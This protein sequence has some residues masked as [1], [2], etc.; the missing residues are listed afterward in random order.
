MDLGRLRTMEDECIAMKAV[1]MA[2]VSSYD[3]LGYKSRWL[4]NSTRA[5]RHTAALW[6]IVVY[7]YNG[8]SV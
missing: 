2:I 7:M 8:G 5:W 6:S 3:G 4:G 1:I